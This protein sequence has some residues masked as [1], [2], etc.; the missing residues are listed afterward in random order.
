MNVSFTSRRMMIYAVIGAAALA[1]G[2]FGPSPDDTSAAVTREPRDS[3]KTKQNRST[4][5]PNTAAFLARLA[6]RTA[7]SK[8]SADLFASHSWYVAPPPPPPAP[9]A[10]PAPPVVPTAP[11]LPFTLLGSY[12]ADGEQAT[13]FLERGDRIYDVRA[14]DEI[15]AEYT[16]LSADGSNL[17]FNY[18][19]LNSRQSLAL[20]GTQ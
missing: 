10:P 9:A 13:Y 11:T 4:L 6:H 3:S 14:G 18:K 7:D 16:L 8:S 20:G 19:P 12:T 17:V 5:N 15:D 1:F 2:I